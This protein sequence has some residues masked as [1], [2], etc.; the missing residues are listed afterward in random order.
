MPRLLDVLNS[1]LHSAFAAAGLPEALGVAVLSGR[2]ELGQFQCNGALA[3]AKQM[4]AN[5]RAL[6]EAA[7]AE[8]QKDPRLTGIGVA[9]P[10]FVNLSLTDAAL[11]AA[12]EAMRGDDRLGVPLDGSGRTTILDYGGPNVAKTMH[13]GHLRSSIIGDSLT[14]LCRFVGDRAISDVHLGDWGTPM[15]MVI[16]EIALRQPELPYFDPA[17]SGPY[18]EE[19]PVT[20]ADLEAIYPAANTAAK[21]DPARMEMARQATAELQAGRPGYRALWQHFVNVSI[22]AMQRDFGALGIRF[23]LWNGEASVDS[24]IPAMIE[25]LKARGIAREDAG[26]LVVDVA[27][28]GDKTEMPPL[29]LLKSD[30][31]AMYGTTDLATVMERVVSYE[32]QQILYVVDQ[33]QHLHFEQVFRAARRG[34]LQGGASLE[35]IGFG[36]INGPDGKPFKTRA[37]GVMKLGDLLAMAEDAALARLAEAELAQ[38]LSEDD[39]RQLARQIGLGAV[40]FADLS[41]PRLSNYIFDLDRFMRFEGKTGPYLQYAAVRTGSVLRRAEAQGIAP[42]PVQQPATEPE[43][44]LMLQLLLL[45]DAVNQA[46]EKRTPHLLC[47]YAFQLA[48]AYSSFYAACHILTETDKDRQASWLSLCVATRAVLVRVLD[49]LGIEVPDRM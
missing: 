9:G 1:A 14:R 32:P 20:T 37:G 7:V 47:D 29:I 28:E 25:R 44:M 3:A 8:L 40:K 11:G 2:P 16:S 15:G 39:R 26:A 36:T 46:Y 18:P 38:D 42:G 43:R 30:G 19:S 6:A 27:Q 21:S 12:V 17:F 34:A 22:A 23:D 35:H 13:V 45:P 10:G 31:A 5:P 48:Q 41:N 33:R 49:L 24:L 4:G